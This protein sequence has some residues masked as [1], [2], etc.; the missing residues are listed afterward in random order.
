MSSGA[1]PLMNKG[2]SIINIASIAAMHPSPMLGLYSTLK[3]ALVGMSRSF[4]LEYGKQG[5]RVNTVIPGLIDTVLADA[6]DE[7]TKARAIRVAPMNR[8]G[9]PDDVANAIVYL[10]S[11]ASSY[12][13]GASLV[14]D[15]GI[16]IPNGG[17]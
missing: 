10:A 17:A 12:V 7:K 9:L 2:G 5:I 3:T 6:F 13:T 15:G 11:A 8:I 4:A 1:I 14:V 16:T